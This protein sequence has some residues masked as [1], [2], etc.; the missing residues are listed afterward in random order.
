MTERDMEELIRRVCKTFQNETGMSVTDTA[1]KE[2]LEPA[3][4]HLTEVTQKLYEHKIS[5]SFLEES[6]RTVLKNARS[7]AKNQNKDYIG[8]IAI[9]N[10][11]AKECPYA[12]WC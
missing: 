2:L 8:F 3:I 1:I 4:P 6:I 11:M 5:A 12:F 7:I 9:K 10:S